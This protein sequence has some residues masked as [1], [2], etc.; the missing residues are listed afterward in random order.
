MTDLLTPFVW[1]ALAALV[2]LLLGLAMMLGRG[3]P[4]NEAGRKTFRLRPLRRLFGLLL[5]ALACVSG[6]LTL[7]LVQFHRLTSDLPVATVQVRQQG[8]DQFVLTADS[9]GQ[10][11]RTYTLY[12][13]QWQI[14]A[15]VVRWRL[16][17]LAA[18]APPLYRLERL[19]GRYQD[20]QREQ[21]DL[22]SVHAMDDWPAPDIGAVKRWFPDWLPFVD[23]TFGSAAYMPLIDGARYEVMFD[24]RGALFIR[25]ADPATTQALRRLGW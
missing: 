12:G 1:I 17:A 19:S 10:P 8:P 16:P 2:A 18:G 5:A 4:R 3:G 23:V 25:P 15:K 21:R 9:E 22:R 13:D 20:V 7:S 14:D 6:L 11:E 24:P